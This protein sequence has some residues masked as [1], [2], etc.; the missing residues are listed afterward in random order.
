MG[1][2]FSAF[3][4]HEAQP[5]VDVL[6]LSGAMVAEQG[7]HAEELDPGDVYLL[8]VLRVDAHGLE[9]GGLD[10]GVL[11]LQEGARVQEEVHGDALVD[12]GCVGAAFIFGVSGCGGSCLLVFDHLL[13]HCDVKHRVILS[14]KLVDVFAGQE[15]LV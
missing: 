8:L 7:G 11:V 3:W 12:G 15:V 5:E 1:E 9:D 13:L 14:V 2:E 10:D 6:D 4:V